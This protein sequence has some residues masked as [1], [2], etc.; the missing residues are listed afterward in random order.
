MTI[1]FHWS[2]LNFSNTL[3]EESREERE[4]A[5]PIISVVEEKFID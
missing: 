3:I 4:S 2:Y 1:V 5:F